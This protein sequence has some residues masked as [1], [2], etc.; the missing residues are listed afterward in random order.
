MRDVH[1]SLHGMHRAAHS[2][3]FDH[4]ADYSTCHAPAAAA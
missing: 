4:S 3:L 2:L 1:A